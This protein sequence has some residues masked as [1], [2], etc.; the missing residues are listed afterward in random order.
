MWILLQV[1][2][3]LVYPCHVSVMFNENIE[4]GCFFC[5]L[6]VGFVLLYAAGFTVIL[7]NTNSIS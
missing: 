7:F 4:S 5:E 6:L 2:K 3:F 1:S